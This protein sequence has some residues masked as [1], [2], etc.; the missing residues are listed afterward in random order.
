[1]YRS[2]IAIIVLSLSI[3]LT[4]AVAQTV[5]SPQAIAYASQAIAAVSGGV[6]IADATLQGTV[7]WGGSS[8]TATLQA[9]GAGESRVDF[10]LGNGT[11]TEIRDAQTGIPLGQ[12]ANPDGSSGRFAYH[13]CLSDAAWFFP[14]LS[15]L[16]AG[17]N[18]VLSYV[19]LEARN[20]GTVQ[21]LRAIQQVQGPVLNTNMQKLTTMDWYLD[22][23][24]FLPVAVTFNTHPDNNLNSDLLV[25]VDY[26]NY[27]KINGILVPGRIQRYQQGALMLDVTV[28]GASFNSGLS[29]TN[30]SIN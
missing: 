7:V 8:G 5:S 1:M 24:T 20:G 2:L 29:L 9:L 27:Q 12:W 14:A 10:L 22:A 26:S 30:F 16:S 15:S 18:V 17:P 21:H 25:E 11:R 23:T 6:T 28:T 19:G 13:N 4:P 3:L